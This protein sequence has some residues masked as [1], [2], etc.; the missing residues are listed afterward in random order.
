MIYY[1]PELNPTIKQEPESK[2]SNI[3]HDGLIQHYVKPYL[4]DGYKFDIRCYMLIN[5]TPELVLF[6]PGYLRFTLE[7]YS[8]ED[9]EDTT[10]LFRHLTNNC[11]Q[12]KHKEYKQKC[13]DTIRGWDCIRESIGEEKTEAVLKEIKKLLLYVYLSAQ[14]RI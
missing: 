9:V 11:F 8:E 14:K 5:A 1:K 2:Y 6:N 4:I 3:K 10:K 7:K 13:E 12:R